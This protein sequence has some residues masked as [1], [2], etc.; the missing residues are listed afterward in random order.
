MEFMESGEVA[1]MFGISQA[2]VA[3]L[4]RAGRLPVAMRVGARGL[5]LYDR[6]TME[7]IAQERESAKRAAAAC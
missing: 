6:A 3:Q 1:R 4:T 5:R 2:R 7:R